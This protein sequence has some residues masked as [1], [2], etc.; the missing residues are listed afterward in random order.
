MLKRILLTIAAVAALALTGCATT[1]TDK[2]ITDKIQTSAASYDANFNAALRA[3]NAIHPVTNSDRAAGLI[4]G[5][6][7]SGG[8][9]QVVL[10]RNGEMDVT[11]SVAPGTF[12]Y[13]TSL[14]KEQQAVVSALRSAVR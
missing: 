2:P 10:N 14:E 4:N 8:L 11:T 3:L 5:H 9:V 13:G 1:F 7:P 6:S 12:L